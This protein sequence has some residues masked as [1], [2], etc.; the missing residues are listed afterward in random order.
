MQIFR[1]Y[2]RKCKQI[3]FWVHWSFCR[4]SGEATENIILSVKNKKVSGRLREVLKQK[5]SALRASSAV[6]V[7][8]LMQCTAPLETFQK[9]VLTNNPEHRRLMN[10]RLPWYIMDSPVGLQLVLL[11]RDKSL[12]V[13]TFS[14]VRAVHCAICCWLAACQLHLSPATFSTAC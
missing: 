5:L 13:S 9:Q 10:T 14:S 1:R 4:L 8:Q 3:V 6:R 11:T 2:G 7:C 12:T